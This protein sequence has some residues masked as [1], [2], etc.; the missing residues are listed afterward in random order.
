MPY[1]VDKHRGNINKHGVSK[2]SSF[3]LLIS[4]P[5]DALDTNKFKNRIGETFK[6]LKD[7]ES[8]GGAMEWEEQG[9]FHLAFRCENITLPGRIIITSPYKEGN[10]GLNREYPTNA[11]YQPVSATFV[12]SR[13]LREKIF[14][15]IWQDLIVGN[16]R[17]VGDTNENFSTREL[18][19]IHNHTSTVT[20]NVYDE[21]GRGQ[22]QLTYTCILEEAYPRTIND[23]SLDWGSNDVSKMN[24]LFDYKYFLDAIIKPISN[25]VPSAADR[26]NFF[27]TSGLA[28]GAAVLG[29]RAV[30]G[31][32]QKQQMFITGAAAAGARLFG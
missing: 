6:R 22:R 16:H 11:V 24:V 26:A 17:S 25:D 7:E 31:M 12:L 21:V 23:I 30:A 27:T 1:D 10:Y 9:Y 3:L 32:T 15:E 4:T 2:A 13:D 29:G 14:F 18:N 28:Q 8:Q 5:T 19:Y 20:I